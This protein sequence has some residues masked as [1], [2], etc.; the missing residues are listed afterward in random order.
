MKRLDRVSGNQLF[1]KCENFQKT[2]AFK[3]RGAVNAIAHLTEAERHHGVVTHS[4]GNHAQALAKA[5]AL[6]D[7][8]AYVV[9]PSTAPIVKK[10]AVLGYGGRVTECEPTLE[11]RLTTCEAVRQ[12]TG[13]TVIPPFD[14]PHII[15]G[16]ATCAREFLEEVPNLDVLIA[17]IGGGGLISGTCVSAPRPSIPGGGNRRRT[18]RC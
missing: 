5:A 15:A 8:P 10:N 4:S 2:G 18:S 11:A 7:I 9:M 3:F 17:P 12:Q 6:H 16:Q 1:F 14:H 13:A